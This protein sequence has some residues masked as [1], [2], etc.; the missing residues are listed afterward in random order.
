MIRLDP[1]IRNCVPALVTPATSAGEPDLPGMGRLVEQVVAAGADAVVVLGSTGEFSIV[2]PHFRAGVLRA[3]VE[4]AAERIPVIAGCGRPSIA[5]TMA[6]IAEARACGAAAAMVTPSYYFPLGDEE[7]AA[8][9]R[10]VAKGA[11]LPLLY[12]HYPEMTGCRVGVPTLVR[13][14][15][16][17]VISG[18]KDSGG[19]AA[20]FARLAAA[21]RGRDDF[22][23]FIGGS[24]YLLAALALGADGVTGGLGNFAT[25]LDRALIDAFRNGDM[26]RAREAQAAIVRAN[27]AT[28]FAV[29]RNAAAIA[30][31]VLAALGVCGE[32]T[33]PPIAPLAPEERARVHNGLAELGWNA[34]A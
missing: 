22:R 12:Y 24:A 1:R 21:V 6:E 14:V 8:F 9:F 5:E 19:D 25:H 27:A 23:L 28:F 33:F 18:L 30:K 4:A 3:A 2:P 34:I 16:D 32:A 7:I 26:A 29:P 10:A 11:E 15:D 17:G 13:L 31:V 20:F